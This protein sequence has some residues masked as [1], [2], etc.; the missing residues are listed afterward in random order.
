[1]QVS[2]RL[3]VSAIAVAA[4]TTASIVAVAVTPTV[5][6]A[7]APAV[8]VTI[9]PT[10]ATAT[11]TPEA[12]S[13]N[14]L[15][16]TA[17][18]DAAPPTE[19][20]TDNPADGNH[21]G[22]TASPTGDPTGDADN[23]TQ[24]G[25]DATDDAE[26]ADQATTETTNPVVTLAPTRAADTRDGTGGVPVGRVPAGQ[27]LRVPVLG[28]HGIP[29]TGV[30]GVILNV[31]V[32]D[33]LAPGYVSA[34]PADS[35][36]TS[37]SAVNYVGEETIANQVVVS[38]G[39]TGVVALYAHSSTHIVV[40]VAGY[41]LSSGDA[42]QGM[43]PERLLDTRN[44]TGAR[45][46]QLPGGSSVPVQ[47]TGRAGIPAS[48][49]SAVILTV[50]VTEPLNSGFVSAYP[51]G[52]ARPTAST[53]NVS[54]GGTRSAL[55]LAGVSEDGQVSL[56]SHMTT[57]LVA[58]VVGYFTT[59]S[60]F[61]PVGPTRLLDTRDPGTPVGPD[62]SVDVTITSDGTTPL[63]EGSATWLNVTSVDSTAPGFVTTYPAGTDRPLASMSNYAPGDVIAN[64][65]M[66]KVGTGGKVTVYAQSQTHLVVDLFAVAGSP[67]AADPTLTVTVPP[68]RSWGL[69]ESLSGQVVAEGGEGPY[70][71]AVTSGQLPPGTTLTQS[72]QLVGSSIVPGD[73]D[74]T[75]TATD[76]TGATGFA[77]LSLTYTA[78]SAAL[79]AKRVAN[80]PNHACAIAQDGTLWCWGANG[81][82]QLGRGSTSDAEHPAPVR[83]MSGVVDVAVGELH[84]CAVTG[85]GAVWCWGDGSDGRTGT[86]ADFRQT[87]P[88]KL[89]GING[90]AA[91]TAGAEHTCARTTSGQAWCWGSNATGQLG[92]N[93]ATHRS[94]PRAV[95]DATD[96]TTLSAGMQH[97][98]GATGSGQVVCWGR[99]QEGQTGTGP[100]VAATSPA[101]T[102]P[103]VTDATTVSSGVGHACATN[104][105]GAV[106]CWGWNAFGQITGN[107]ADG[108]ALPATVVNDLPEA[109]SAAAGGWH[110]CAT[111]TT[112]DLTCWGNN[113][114]G[115]RG[116]GAPSGTD[117]TAA[118]V[119]AVGRVTGLAASWSTTCAVL[120][121]G[122]VSCWGDGRN[123]KLG[124]R[125]S[126][127]RSVPSS[128]V[129]TR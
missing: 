52:T 44:G 116:I 37:A 40:D 126:L 32:T 78:P 48:G 20:D 19:T 108:D 66:A 26:G 49:V 58:D 12:T 14:V 73:Y 102:V 127:D 22:G 79:T 25:G 71:F 122:I 39:T 129:I 15:G 29:G 101:T 41:I 105:A 2:R 31:T 106:T 51:S 72:G 30:A 50:T 110:T 103:G 96:F 117:T 92:D 94:A 119:P 3:T 59:E 128:V 65:I 114:Y 89:G 4:L 80:G 46:G 24:P 124:D 57:H 84:T 67:E 109:V 47:V 27:T 75:I 42:Y 90:A 91:I 93:T 55:V 54:A 123:R 81:S 21:D 83:G 76:T 35:E 120:P 62:G 33:S 88:I 10:G 95:P 34:H 45:Q 82:G 6:A 77:D 111:S 64:S 36:R 86:E 69:G 112:G 9:P 16:G 60:A 99:S 115:Q 53:L 17:T 85:D 63:P 125:A 98:C 74:V 104:T 87:T 61:G 8:T 56:Y 18:D 68:A 107:P 28:R 70:Q 7:T 23:V 13:N 43:N 100:A 113:T 97:T 118:T 11:E 38:P 1:M 5:Q 121:G